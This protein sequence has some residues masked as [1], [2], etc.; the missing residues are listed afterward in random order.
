[1]YCGD[2]TDGFLSGGA[3]MSGLPDDSEISG[4]GSAVLK[5]RVDCTLTCFLIHEQLTFK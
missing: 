3:I 5:T 4:A 1:M 2:C